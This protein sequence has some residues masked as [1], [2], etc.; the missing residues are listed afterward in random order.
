MLYLVLENAR[1]LTLYRIPTAAAAVS[2]FE[3]MEAEA[4]DAVDVDALQ[5]R[6]LRLQNELD[7]AAP[8]PGAIER[9]AEATA[10]HAARLADLEAAT[11][12]RDAVD[13]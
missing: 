12:T 10:E 1:M 5:S 2:P 7:E 9:H 8:E 6:I 3:D 13:F 4:L 11:A